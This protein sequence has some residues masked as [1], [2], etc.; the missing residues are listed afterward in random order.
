MSRISLAALA[1]FA[2][3]GALPA[4]ADESPFGDIYTTDTL[5]KGGRE[6]EQWLT[7]EHGRPFETF[8]H[9]AGRTEIEYGITSR[10]QASLYLNYD[11]FEN[12]PHS[13][14]ADTPHQNFARFTGVSG[15]VIYRLV[16]PYTHPI[17]VAL[18]LEPLIGSDNREVEFKVLLQKNFL[19][20][21]LVLA[22]NGVLEYEWTKDEEE[23]AHNT[24]VKALLGLS[25]RFAPN[26]FAG[27][28]FMFK[29]EF[30]GHVFDHAIAAADSFFL[31]PTVH[32]T[33]DKWWVTLS[34]QFQLPAAGNLNGEENQVVAGFAHEEPRLSLRLRFGYEF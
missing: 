32:Y 7:Y 5:P 2:L 29:R 3:F 18:Y 1:A 6:V 19:D 34:S 13:D 20:D 17:G 15:E 16:D 21:R 22:A 25:Y 11:W 28:E 12:S 24:E 14:K 27:A 30:D 8:N 4:F 33:H 10:L 23:W 31:G 26:W 9:L